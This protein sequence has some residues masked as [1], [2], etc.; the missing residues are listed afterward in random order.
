MK[1]LPLIFLILFASNGFAQSEENREPVAILEIGGA[2]GWSLT[3]P[4]SSFGP[5]VAMEFTPIEK[6]LEI[7][8]GT[9]SSFGRHSTEWGT[10]F[11]FKKPWDWNSNIEFMIG[12]G[13]EWIHTR[14]S[15]IRSNSLAGEAVID[16][17]FWTNATHRIGWYFEPAYEHS[18]RAGHEKS[19]AFSTGLLIGIHR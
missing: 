17:M 12:I 4:G 1:F 13:P 14:Q 10:D 15:G 18:F 5:V 16:L 19:L 9:T 8:V 3:D 6:W 11:L 2:P 7:E